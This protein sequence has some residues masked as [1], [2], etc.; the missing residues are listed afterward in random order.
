VH[1]LDE[2]L[3]KRTRVAGWYNQCIDEIPGIDKPYIAETTARMSWFV[4]VV[5]CSD[6]VGR[7]AL[8]TDLERNGIPSRAYFTPIHLQP[9]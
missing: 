1:R 5:R 8:M 7:N 4:Y 2:L 6:A 9:L 3:E